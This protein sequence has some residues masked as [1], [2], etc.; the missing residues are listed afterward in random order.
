M[1]ERRVRV[2][3][4]A[5]YGRSQPLRRPQRRAWRP[6]QIGLW[7]QRAILLVI[8]VCGVVWGLSKAFAT[9]EVTVLAGA[10]SPRVLKA[11]HQ[12]VGENAWYGNLLTLDPGGLASKLQQADPILKSVN[13][14]RKLP[15]T[16][17]VTVSL[18]QPSLGWSTG[19]QAYLLDRDG[20]AIGPLPA[21]SKLAVVTDGSNLP[22]KAGDRVASARFVAFVGELVPALAALGLP[23]AHL[24]VADTTQ[25][26]SIQTSK[27][28][29]L[30][31]DTS[32]SVKDELFDLKAVLATLAI[33]KK[34]PAEYIDLRI[35]GKAY[36]K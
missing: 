5:T 29:R 28:Y 9:T 8:L 13:V 27:G 16:I 23:A 21:G 7:Q 33:Q 31:F 35:S 15:H 26:L 1:T 3:G 18:K 32:R 24:D 11:V 34:T 4:R 22:V 36:Y 19:N 30:I 6:P 2:S 14:T 12:L 20:T 17:T 25:D 10:E